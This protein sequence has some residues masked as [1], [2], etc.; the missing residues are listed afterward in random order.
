MTEEI[1]EQDTTVPE[2]E[3]VETPET[4]A[5]ENA[6]PAE[7]AA[8]PSKKDKK[9]EEKQLK[10]ENKQLTAKLAEATAALDKAKAELTET[11]DKY[12]RV[13]AEYDNF[14]KRSAKEREGIFADAY[15]DALKEILPVID[16]LERAA[17]YTEPDKLV[18]GLQLIFKGAGDMLAK[19]GVE[20][21]GEAGDK[22]DPNIHNAVMHVEDEAIEEETVVEVFQKGYKKGDRIIRHAMVKVAN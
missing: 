10:D 22:F 14:R 20:A 16:N 6:A 21:F 8:E 17:N 15:S 19:L 4:Q 18:D 1:K 12:M 13:C 3:T 7:D 9:R 5:G 2:E 11:T